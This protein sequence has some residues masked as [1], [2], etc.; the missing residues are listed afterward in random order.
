LEDSISR[1]QGE[2][3]AIKNELDNLRE[4]KRKM[5]G[6]MELLVEANDTLQSKSLE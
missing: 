5:I 3:V 2:Q 1:L 4:H 6:D